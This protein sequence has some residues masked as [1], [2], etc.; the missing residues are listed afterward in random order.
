MGNCLTWEPMLK[1]SKSGNYSYM[2]YNKHHN[3][4]TTP[5]LQSVTLLKPNL[6][7]QLDVLRL[8]VLLD[9]DTDYMYRLSG[10]Y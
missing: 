7:W 1:G 5:L 6:T 10:S 9:S 3:I 2:F 4:V 8:H